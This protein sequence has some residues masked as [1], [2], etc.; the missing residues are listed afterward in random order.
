MKVYAIRKKYDNKATIGTTS[1]EKA[2]HFAEAFDLEVDEVEIDETNIDDLVAAYNLGF[3]KAVEA[4]KGAD[5]GLD[6]DR[7]LADHLVTLKEG[8]DEAVRD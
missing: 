5:H 1:K 8:D 7:Y 6:L 2:Q 3:K 4:I